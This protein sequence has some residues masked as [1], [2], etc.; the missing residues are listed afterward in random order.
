MVAQEFMK[1]LAS[2]KTL[3]EFDAKALGRFTSVRFWLIS[4]IRRVS[5]NLR[6][7]NIMVL[8]EMASPAYAIVRMQLEV[9]MRCNAVFLVDDPEALCNDLLRGGRIGSLRDRNGRQMT[10]AYLFQKYKEIEAT[11]WTDLTTRIYEVGC[12]H[13]HFSA[14]AAHR[15]LTYIDNERFLLRALGEDDFVDENELASI[16]IA[17]EVATMLSE[18]IIGKALRQIP[19]P[20]PPD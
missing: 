17:M 20:L 18:T 1:L 6:A 4:A 8:E 13:V 10:D 7:F 16:T 5:V 14:A 15:S 3:M 19:Q 9:G 12:M 11:K 2:H